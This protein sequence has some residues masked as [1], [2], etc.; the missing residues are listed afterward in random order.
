MSLH[1]LTRDEIARINGLGER[2]RDA[3]RNVF[4]GLGIEMQVTGM[5]SVLQVHFTR[6]PVHDYRGTVSSRSEYSSWLH[7]SLLN[8]GMFTAGRGMVCISTAMGEKQ[9]AEAIQGF[10]A[11][12]EQLQS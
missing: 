1:L 3:L 4:A 10:K 2:L 7:L 8:L 5:G 11:A 9:V 6:N 12:A